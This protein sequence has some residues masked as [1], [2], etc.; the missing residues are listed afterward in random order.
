MSVASVLGM[1]VRRRLVSP[2]KTARDKNWTTKAISAFLPALNQYYEISNK[3]FLGFIMF[4][5]CR[6]MRSFE[7]SMFSLQRQ[8]Q[9]LRI[10][11]RNFY[12]EITGLLRIFSLEPGGGFRLLRGLYCDKI[13]WCG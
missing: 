8:H 10:P 5:L 7:I 2:T 9:N 13:T 6:K 4:V 3:S 1:R 12:A 11:F